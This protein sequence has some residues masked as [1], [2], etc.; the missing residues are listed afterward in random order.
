MTTTNS[1]HPC[2][3]DDF[4]IVASPAAPAPAKTIGVLHVVNGQHYAGAERVQDLLSQ[5]LPEFGFHVGFAC[6][7]PDRFPDVRWAK[8]SP[9]YRIPMRTRID[10]RPAWTLARI[11]HDEGYQILHAH[12]PR[13]AMIG[14]L[15]AAMAGVPM[16]YHVH[17][18][19]S[20]DTTGRWTNRLNA[21]VERWAVARASRMI[22]VSES[23]RRHMERQ[24]FSP[25][26]LAVVHNGVPM[27]ASQVMRPRPRD[28]WTLGTVA[29]FRPR[30]GTETLIDALALL[31]EQ[32]LPVHLR[33]VGP[34][35][36]PEYEA[37]LKTR[38]AERGLQ[39]HVEWVGFSEHV[40]AELARM[41]LFVLPSLFG[42]GLPMVVL[43]AMAAGVPVVATDVEG[44]PEAI[45]DGREGL[46][47]PPDDPGKLAHAIGRIVRGEVDWAGLRARALSR[48]V[49]DFSDRSMAARVAA[50]YREILAG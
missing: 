39:P 23:L 44:I 10:V 3:I 48:Q 20:R 25:S 27:R 41:D 5:R 42:E 49:K 47:V 1:T 21:L 34:F 18:P 7:K 26:R 14:R 22:V 17:S 24:G 8:D 50:V 40:N 32:G 35:E 36:T 15:A 46:I 28:S 11:V 19:T 37:L 12:T 9:L 13:T 45:E 29:L 4:A 16:V 38:V 33:A 31:R 2:P 6:V 30:K 43:E